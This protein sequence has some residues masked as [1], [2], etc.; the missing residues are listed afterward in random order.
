[1]NTNGHQENDE[2]RMSNDEGMP[3]SSKSRAQRFVI[4]ISDLFRHSSFGF[5]HFQWFELS[6]SESKRTAG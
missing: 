6:K 4:Q 3:K 1:M 2:A 5:R